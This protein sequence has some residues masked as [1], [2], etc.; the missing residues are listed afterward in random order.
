M[1][2]SKVA[3]LSTVVVTLLYSTLLDN[4]SVKGLIS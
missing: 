4:L 1:E 2:G 3:K